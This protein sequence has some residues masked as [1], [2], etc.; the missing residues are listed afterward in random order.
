M[1]NTA[2]D[3]SYL[4]LKIEVWG[5]APTTF[6]LARVCSELPG[7]DAEPCT[8]RIS[9][10]GGLAPSFEDMERFVLLEVRST[11]VYVPLP[12]IIGDTSTLVHVFAATA[13]LDATTGPEAGALA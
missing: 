13:P 9:S 11:R 4:F 1:G 12:V 8:P 2:E 10:R 5:G 3:L 6:A 7:K